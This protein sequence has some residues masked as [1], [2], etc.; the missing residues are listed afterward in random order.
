MGLVIA[1]YIVEILL[2]LLLFPIKIRA[3][4]YFSLST[5]SAGIDFEI[6]GVAIIRIRLTNDKGDLCIK[7]NDKKINLTSIKLKAKSN[8]RIAKLVKNLFESIKKR[9]IIINGDVLA[10]LGDDDP[11][12]S[13]LMSGAANVLFNMIGVKMRLYSD[14]EK[15]RADADFVLNS[16]INVIQALQAII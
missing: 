12:T 3:K 6:F 7:V 9:E 10:V 4:G 14:F 2:I 13:A 15:E 8:K 11:K 5:I 16:K 1:L